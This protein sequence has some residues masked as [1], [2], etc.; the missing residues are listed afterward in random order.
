MSYTLEIGATAPD[1]SLPAT[2]G[3]VY[4]LNH[5]AHAKAFVVFF[6]CN[7]CPYATGCHEATKKTAEKFKND[8]VVFIGINSNSKNTYA[9]DSFE[10]MVERMKVH[11]Y[12]WVYLYDES[13]QIARKFGALKTPHFFLFDQD[14]KLIYTGRSIDTPK[15]PSK[16]KTDDLERALTDYLSK[17]SIS[18]PKTNPIG[19]N[20]KWEGKPSHWMPPEACD[21]V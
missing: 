14:R 8:G 11:K 5:F 13:Q 20:I 16:M 12:P 9:E 4:S 17:K 21:L 19:C 2:D 7:H 10:H 18:V 15:D 3:K 1:F 6:T